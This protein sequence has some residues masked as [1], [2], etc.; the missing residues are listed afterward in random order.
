M[1]KFKQKMDIDLEEEQFDY[2]VDLVANAKNKNEVRAVLEVAMMQSDRTVVSQR[3]D[4]LR[5]LQKN[6]TYYE[7]E[8]ELKVSSG[9]IS[10]SFDQ[11]LKSGEHS[12]CFMDVLE[13]TKR[14]V[15]P[16]LKSRELKKYVQTG[17]VRQVL[18]ENKRIRK[19][20]SY[21]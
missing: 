21:T 17:G 16:K 6:K 3:V 13:R 9:T 14:R 11:Y 15:K 20:R 7:I 1:R 18:R 2:F 12:R 4:I 5:L 19:K 8:R 10:N